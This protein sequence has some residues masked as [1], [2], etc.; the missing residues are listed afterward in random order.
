MSVLSERLKA[1]REDSDMK[2]DVL[3]EMLGVGRS[4]ISNM[5]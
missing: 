2:Q 5:R 1:L 3:A 4:I